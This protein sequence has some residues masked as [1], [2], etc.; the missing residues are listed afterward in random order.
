MISPPGSVSVI[1]LILT[2]CSLEIVGAVVDLPVGVYVRVTSVGMLHIPV[3]VARVRCEMRFPF[4]A[5]RIQITVLFA[6]RWVTEPIRTRRQ[7]PVLTASREL[8]PRVLYRPVGLLFSLP[9]LTSCHRNMVPFVSAG[10][11]QYTRFRFFLANSAIPEK[12]RHPQTRRNPDT[13]KLVG[14]SNLG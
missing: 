5:I 8:V 3:E 4:I 6:P 14:R 2:T 1:A 9:R 12:S 10:R 11:R 13:Q 7:I